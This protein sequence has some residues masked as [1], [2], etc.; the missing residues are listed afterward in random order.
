MDELD[1][2]VHERYVSDLLKQ[3]DIPVLGATYSYKKQ[4]EIVQSHLR[5]MYG[6]MA[7]WNYNL[8]LYL[9][10]EERQYATIFA[11]RVSDTLEIPIQ[12]LEMAIKCEDDNNLL[13]NT[14]YEEFDNWNRTHNI[15][16]LCKSAEILGVLPLVDDGKRVNEYYVIYPVDVNDRKLLREHILKEYLN[17]LIIVVQLLVTMYK[18]GN[19]L[20]YPFVGTMIT[21]ARGRMF[22]RGENAYYG[23]SKPSILRTNNGIPPKIAE[24]ITKLKYDECGFF[25]DRIDAVRNWNCRYGNVN[26]MALMQHY[27]LPTH[28][29]DITSDIKTA[30]FFACCK[31][32][33]NG[34]LSRWVPLT[35]Y[36]FEK[37]DS[38]PF[39][40]NIGGDSRYGM[41]F[42]ARA[43][44]EDLMW[45]A[46]KSP[47]DTDENAAH[48]QAA[49]HVIPAGYQPFGRCKAQH[50]Y[51]LLGENDLYM[52][53]HFDKAKFRLDED[54]CRWIYEEMDCGKKIYPYDDVPDITESISQIANT[55]FFSKSV[56]DNYCNVRNMKSEDKQRLKQ[57]LLKHGFFISENEIKYIDED[58][59]RQINNEYTVERAFQIADID[60]KR[61]PMFVL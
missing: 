13:L 9:N 15:N 60:I 18:D 47:K 6:N 53:A 50:A 52:D 14:V 3:S 26:Y 17:I 56:F 57:I 54:F 49:N 38:R 32:E 28:M 45:L 39:V 22:W 59:L 19:L 2:T 30:L 36:D 31:W 10:S 51:I 4:L 41:I 5:T 43:E 16:S 20:S 27:G 33:N 29:M 46:V 24:I 7:D 34:K 21:Q 8:E 12:A 11:E 48:L 25:L 61:F 40:S 23:S 42:K 1:N 37:A 55:K 58:I 44:I 35:K